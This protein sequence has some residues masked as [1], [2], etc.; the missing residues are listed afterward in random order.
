M[1]ISNKCPNS[2]LITAAMPIKDSTKIKHAL[3]I[4][5]KYNT[6]PCTKNKH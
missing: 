1:P 6:M 4:M 2:D 3:K 5:V